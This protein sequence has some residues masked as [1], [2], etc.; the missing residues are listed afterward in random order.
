[1]ITW[2]PVLKATLSYH[3]MRGLSASQI[4][5]KMTMNR[6]QIIGACRRSGFKLKRS[7][8]RHQRTGP[9]EP[10]LLGQII[11]TDHSFVKRM[12]INTIDSRKSC[13]IS[14]HSL[15]SAFDRTEVTR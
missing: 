4:G 10:P 6:N 15:G 9:I 3:V 13:L 5:N 1:M 8:N 2:T 11:P 12:P 7:E 14:L